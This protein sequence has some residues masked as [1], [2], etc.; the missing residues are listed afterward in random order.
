M[1][2]LEMCFLMISVVKILEYDFSGS[3]FVAYCAVVA[4]GYSMHISSMFTSPVV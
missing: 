3:V 4:R 2:L 1:L